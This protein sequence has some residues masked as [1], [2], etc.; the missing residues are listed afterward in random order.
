MPIVIVRKAGLPPDDPILR[1]AEAMEGAVRDAFLR[2][3]QAT[4][5][6]VVLQKLAEAI[7]QGDVNGALA[8]LSIDQNFVA[9]MQGAGIEPGLASF[10]DAIQQVIRTGALAA[11]RALPKAVGLEISFD[12]MNPES[13][14]FI[15]SYTFNLIQ[16]VSADTR[17]AIQQVVL[18]AFREGGHPYEQAREIKRVIG[19]TARQ[20]QAV[21]SYR[22]ALQQGGSALRDALSRSLRDGR[23]DPTLIR[24]MQDQTSL[25]REYIDKLVARYRERF[26]Q[27]RARNIARS[28]TIRAANKGQRELWRQARQQGLIPFT[29][30]RKWIISGDDRTCPLCMKLDGK[31][32]SLDEEFAP[33]ILE[34]PDPHPSCLVGETRVFGERILSSVVRKF[35]GDV[36]VFHTAAGYRLTCTP[37]HPILTNRGWVPAHLLNK[38]DNVI[39]SCRRD[40]IV[41]GGMDKKYMP[42]MI[43]DIVGAALMVGEGSPHPVPVVNEDFHGDGINGDIAVVLPNR[44]LGDYLHSSF[45]EQIL[46]QLFVTIRFPRLLDGLCS[47]FEDLKAYFGSSRSI[48]GGLSPFHPL[49]FAG[50][51]H[52]QAVSLL[53]RPEFETGV[54]EMR[55]QGY[56]SNPEMFGNSVRRP[57][58]FEFEDTILNRDI[59]SFSGHVFNLE[60]ASG[61][62]EANGII[63]HNCRC[64]TALV[65]ASLKRLKVA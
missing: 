31:M 55:S 7:A 61:E 45:F 11:G 2:A 6:K 28:E 13:A 30:R 43:Q 37:N 38:S 3:I 1:A 4:R 58:G 16:Q 44:L 52:S 8:L 5:D 59:R 35:Y 60:T 53:E 64:T 33:G 41:S 21:A 56:T 36:L 46:E 49:A 51:T 27:Y 57:T 15:Q 19:L 29:A 26:I 39:S 24:A 63:T 50:L 18:R 42:P 62:Y 17:D 14:N 48:M 20:E 12:L 23:Y 10:R 25:R 47:F 9:A 22:A 40:W 32:A 34:P 65:A 54:S